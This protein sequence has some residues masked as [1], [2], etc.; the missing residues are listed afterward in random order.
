M[1]STSPQ[2]RRIGVIG[3][4]IIGTCTA[5]W[6][7]RLASET[8]TT[9]ASGAVQVTL[10]EGSEIAAGASG[11]AGGLLALDWH[12]SVPFPP[13]NGMTSSP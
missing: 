9:T 7:G 12:G 5:F 10:I 4:G 13:P 3:G 1:A 6:L 11:K 8:A 2:P